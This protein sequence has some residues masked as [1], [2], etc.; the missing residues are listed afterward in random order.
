[1]IQYSYHQPKFFSSSF[2]NMG[3]AGQLSEFM[4]INIYCIN[5]GTSIKKNRTNRKPVCMMLMPQNP[6]ETGEPGSPE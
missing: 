6:E 4:F 3:F 1:M 2:T 5:D